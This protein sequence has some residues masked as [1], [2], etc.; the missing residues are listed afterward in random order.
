MSKVENKK[1]LG[2]DWG[3]ARIGLA[4]GE[5]ESKTAV[6]LDTVLTFEEVFQII[7]D[8]EIDELVV[9]QPV[10][11]SGD[12][13]NLNKE[14]IGFVEILKNKINIPIHF[15]DERLTSKA[16]DSLAGDKK[17]KAGRDAIAAMLIL[18]SYL[19]T[20]Y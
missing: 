13:I 12:K 14:Y 8:E 11:M 15:V 1:Y 16:A 9:G 20:L 18:Q 10:K 5:S 17:T 2:L 7:K 19:D 6:P 3:E 4:I